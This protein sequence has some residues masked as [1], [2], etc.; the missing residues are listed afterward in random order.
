MKNRIKIDMV[1][2]MKEKNTVAR[3]ILRVLKGEIERNEQSSKGKVELSDSEVVKLTKKL[4]ESVKESGEDNG[5][6]AVLEQYVP[7]QMSFDNVAEEAASFI[8]REGLDSPREMGKVM[9]YFKQNFE[10]IYDGKELSQIV[11]ELLK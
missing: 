1:T 8:A 4:I 2:A 9:A 3:D 10:G 7:K 5:E 11:K 6:I